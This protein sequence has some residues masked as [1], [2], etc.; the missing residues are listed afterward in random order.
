MADGGNPSRYVKLTKDQAPLEDIKPGELNQPIEVPQ[1]NVRR[2]N[3]CGQPL[4]ESFEPPADEPWTTG[5]FGCAEDTES[6]WQ[7]L[8]CPCVLFGRNVEKLRED[9]PWTTPCVCHAIFVEGG[10]ALAAGTALFYGIDPRTSF[11]FCEGLLFS[12]WMCGIYTGLVRQSLQKKY[13]LKVI[14]LSLC[15]S[16]ITDIL[17]I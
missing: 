2:C 13:H 6:C 15:L 12:W 17:Q 8:F 4:P 16:V 10:M 9:T 3:E 5:I 1:L 14:I 11:L 7:G